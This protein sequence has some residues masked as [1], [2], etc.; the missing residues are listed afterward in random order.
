MSKALII[1]ESP[2]KAKT[3]QKYLGKDYLVLAS[4][5]HIRDLPKSG[6][7]IDIAHGYKPHYEVLE[8]HK[9]VLMELK[10]AAKEVDEI[11][12]APDP[13]REGEAIA[14]HIA[15]ELKGLKKPIKRV[16]FH[17]ITRKGV[18]EGLAKPREVDEARFKAQQARRVLDR[19]IGY[20]LSPV[21][22]KR[23]CRRV[24]GHY[25]SAG[26]V[27]SAA[28]RLIVD[29]EEEIQAFV[30]QEYW[31]VDVTLVGSSKPA[32]VAHLVEAGGL[33]IVTPSRDR[34]P[35]AGE[36]VVSSRQ[37]AEAIRDSLRGATFVV[38]QIE[39]KE[40]RRKAPPPY[41][42]SS[43]QRDAASRLG[44]SAARTMQV[45]QRL[46]EGIDIGAEGPVGLITYMRTDSTRLANDAIEAVR[47]YIAQRFGARYVPDK[48]NY[49]KAK[50][51]AQD[52]HEAIRPTSTD[53]HPDAI[54][55]YLKPD[56]YKLYRLIWERFIACQ[57]ADAV[58]DS[59]TVLID[60]KSGQQVFALRASG[61]VL[62]FPGWLEVQGAGLDG[63]DEVAGEEAV[64][65]TVETTDGEAA[66]T[67]LLP[68]LKEGETLTLVDPP[69]VVIEQK[70]TQPPPRYNEGTLVKALE[71]LGIGRP[72]T[73]AEIVS[74]VLSRDYVEKR[75]RQLVPTKL[76]IA[77]T[78]ALRKR[79]PQIVSYEF[80]A[81]IEA[82]LDKVEAGER[83]WVALVDSIYKPFHALV[84]QEMK[85]DEPGEGWPRPEPTDRVCD[86]CGR[87]MVRRWGPTTDYLACTG[88]P[89]CKNI[90]DENPPPPPRVFEGRKCPKCGK[91]L[92]VRVAR[93][94]SK[95][96]FLGCSGW[97]ECD[98]TSPMPTG[99][100]CPK[101]GG[102]VVKVG[103]GAKSRRP[104]YG[105]S[106]YQS[107]Q[108]DFR[109][110]QTPVAKPCPEC[111]APFMVEAGGKRRP[112]LKC[113]ADGCTYEEPLDTPGL[114]PDAPT[115]GSETPSTEKKP[116]SSASTAT[117][118]TPARHT[119]TASKR[120]GAEASA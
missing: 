68:E 109:L 6:M 65:D 4:K 96:E 72:S 108:C 22:W 13:D 67:S 115:D 21:L 112:V 53:L 87:P 80:T 110:Y 106:N 10:R 12:L 95:G 113:V 119:K 76:G 60:A 82:D 15:Q 98:Y 91:D 92:L 50:S 11:Y 45:A 97:P 56:E 1:V 86:K 20:E 111:G 38:R 40:R 71:D 2:A 51:S 17:E 74:K 61:Q 107:A 33:K 55:K 77:K 41:I 78:R 83:D 37:E 36:R 100:V 46:Y 118:A 114:E 69:G 24:N 105:C 31:P 28:L 27:Q 57:M 29:R 32:F 43:L 104:F 102:D 3:I 7:Q 101:C 59:T 93:K 120:K 90:V 73:Y 9:S 103:G 8:D 85:S 81:N 25:L 48:P 63:R 34:Q 75:D 84:E 88:Y 5:G 70:F 44:F 14:W 58:Y 30:P 19:L 79:F 42:T 62:K 64:R 49:F 16:E 23:L 47:Q 54:K 99:I 66:D 52:A 35:K 89:E 116:K 39:K 18:Q 94:G 26:R 117:R